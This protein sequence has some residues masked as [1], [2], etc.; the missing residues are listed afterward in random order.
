[1]Y[2]RVIANKKTEHITGKMREIFEE[3]GPPNRYLKTVVLCK[4]LVGFN[5]GVLKNIKTFAKEFRPVGI[6]P[7]TPYV[8]A[9]PRDYI[10]VA[11]LL[12]AW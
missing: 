8:N 6:E 4:V 2:G 5:C 9:H 3:A 1:M 11:H 12:V 7:S 10:T